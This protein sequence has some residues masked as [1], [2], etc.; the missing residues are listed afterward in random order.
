[1]LK[2]RIVFQASD[3]KSNV[4]A[5][6]YSFWQGKWNWMHVIVKTAALSGGCSRIF[7]LFACIRFLIV[8]KPTV[9]QRFYMPFARR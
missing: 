7:A 5:E 9:V 4:K 3:V 1:M 2:Q 8:F 6:F